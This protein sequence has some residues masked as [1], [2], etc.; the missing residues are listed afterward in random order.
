MLI[1]SSILL[2]KVFEPIGELTRIIYTIGTSI[3][4]FAAGLKSANAEVNIV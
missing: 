2:K 1:G 4:K 3:S